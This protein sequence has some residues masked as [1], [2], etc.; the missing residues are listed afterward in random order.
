MK[1]FWVLGWDQY[2]PNIDN[3]LASFDNEADAQE[4]IS[5]QNKYYDFYK[6]VNI[7]DRL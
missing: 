5:Q 1:L 3:F 2:Y 4:Y 7:S 6:I